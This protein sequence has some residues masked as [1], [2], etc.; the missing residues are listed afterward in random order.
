MKWYLQAL[1]KFADFS[2]RARRKEYWF[3]FL[4]N[5]L[6]SIVLAVIDL[7]VGTY[8]A[9]SGLGLL[10]TIYGLG[11]LIP[12][13]AVGVRRLHDINRTGWWIL[14]A[15]VPIIGIIILLIFA[16]LPGT[17]GANDYGPDPKAEA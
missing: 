11:V 5:L 13:I 4:F 6:V 1:K 10:S 16:L 12:S 15:F 7:T 17:E 9:S 8:S 14:I 3:F 2:G